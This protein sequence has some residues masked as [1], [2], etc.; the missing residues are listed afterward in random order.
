MPTN[1]K[2][3]VTNELV[4]VF[5]E[6]GVKKGILFKNGHTEFYILRHANNDQIDELLGTKSE[7]S[8]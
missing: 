3:E 1:K 2:R 8:K 4:R 5:W 7:I 6:D